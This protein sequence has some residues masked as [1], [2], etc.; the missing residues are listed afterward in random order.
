MEIILVIGLIALILI[1]GYVFYSTRRATPTDTT[2]D[3]PTDEV[4][5]SQFQGGPPPDQV[6]PEAPEEELP[7]DQSVEQPTASRED[8][9][10]RSP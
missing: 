6:D 9:E 7:E 5:M 10:R 2:V 1:A 4:P 3:D 8:S